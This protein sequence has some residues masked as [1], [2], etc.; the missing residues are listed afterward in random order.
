MSASCR[1]SA[2]SAISSPTTETMAT[3]LA[4]SY[5]NL[6]AAGMG[7]QHPGYTVIGGGRDNLDAKL[8]F[9]EFRRLDESPGRQTESFGAQFITARARTL[10]LHATIGMKRRFV[11]RPTRSGFPYHHHQDLYYQQNPYGGGGGDYGY[12]PRYVC[13]FENMVS[14]NVIWSAALLTFLPSLLPF[15]PYDASTDRLTEIMAD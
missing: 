2:Q 8:K 3:S 13:L 1:K 14:F 12:Y 10:H 4:S 5:D 15:R 6:A 9:R 7:L 11:D